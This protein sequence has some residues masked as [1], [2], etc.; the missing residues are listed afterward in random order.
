MLKILLVD[1]EQEE[2]EGIS[3]LIKKYGYPLSVSE[4]SNG[5]KALEYMEHHPVDILFT[6]VKMPMMNGLELAKAVNGAYPETKIII[7]SAYGEFDYAKQALEANA[8]N[9]LLKPIE[10][11][12]FR[13]VME[14]LI[15]S[16]QEEKSQQEERK[17]EDWQNRQNVLYKI[18]TGAHL[19]QSEWE[20]ARTGLFPA[21]V[22][23]RLV[24]VE[25]MDNFFEKEEEIF[26]N[27][28][29]MY[30]GVQ[31]EYINLFQNE[32]CLLIREKKYM[33]REFLEGQLL[34]LSRDVE[35]FAADGMFAAVS[36]IFSTMEEFEKEAEAI[37]NIQR[38]FFGFGQMIVWTES[39]RLQ[40]Y[41]SGDVEAVRRQL[42]QAIEANRPELIRRFTDQLLETISA[43]NRMSK[44][45][46]Q[47]IFYTVIQALYSK[48]P[49]IRHEQILNS[50]DILFR[51]RNAR[52]MLALFQKNIYEMLE[53]IQEN[54]E[55]DSGIIQRIKNLVEK[56]Y[57]HDVSLNYVA[58]KVNLAPA[59][60][61]YVFKKET[62][63]TL[64]K[65]ITEIKMEKAKLLLEE[66]CLKVGQIAKACG[67]ENQSY[68]NRAFKNYY[69]LTPK[70]FRENGERQDT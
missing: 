38:E 70:Q 46:V 48:N 13:S 8:V 2:R 28:V 16:I 18:L 41:Y 64:I 62:G 39:G 1:D 3:Y 10:L 50:S 63:Q 69:G 29:R 14:D 23:Y 9:Y 31:T 49:D 53:T 7:F 57:M 55:D 19:K 4:A 56:E 60:V 34:K 33:D 54:T 66:G 43:N 37:L 61:S 51:S 42:M 32:S 20:R 11:D 68:F 44:L 17:Q 27:F 22:S 58:E 45:Y 59:Y 36:R 47:N 6:D 25:F 30:L 65:Y 35:A 26:L 40:E 15:Q 24:H 12:E 5:K 21:G 52:D 67:Y